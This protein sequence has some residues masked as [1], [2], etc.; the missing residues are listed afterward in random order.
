MTLPYA[1][2]VV[3]IDSTSVTN[4]ATATGVVD[5]LGWGGGFCTIDVKLGTAN[6]TSNN[7][8]VFN[9]LEGDTTSSLATVSGGVGDTDWT[10][11]TCSTSVANTY[12]F[13]V[14]LKGRKRYLSLAISPTTTQIVN[15]T[16]NL[17]NGNE[18]A[19]DATKAN[20]GALIS[21]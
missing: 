14:C 7:P 8:S 12:K 19:I 4:G 3:M 17:H 15:A 6:T 21:V 20:V 5:T 13:N 16:A 1:R 18:L 11:P 2:Q 9:L 10:I